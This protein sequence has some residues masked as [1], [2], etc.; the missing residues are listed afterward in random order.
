M[1]AIKA[2]VYLQTMIYSCR[3]EMSKI[4]KIRVRYADM[5]QEATL[6]GTISDRVSLL[7][8]L[9]THLHTG[10]SLMSSRGKLS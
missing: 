4:S 5:T 1:R 9:V 7:M 3:A 6:N 2:Q 8:T 10:E